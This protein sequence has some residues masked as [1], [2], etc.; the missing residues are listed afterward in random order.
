MKFSFRTMMFSIA[1]LCCASSI[2]INAQQPLTQPQLSQKASVSQTIGLTDITITYHRP[3]VKGRAIWG[4]LVPYNQIWRIGADENTTIEFSTP[5]KINGSDLPAGKY[6]LHSIPTDN[7]WTIIFSKDN[8][9]WGSYFYDSTRD[10]LRIQS[11]PEASPFT[12]ALTISFDNPESSSVIASINWDKLKVPFKIEVDLN[13]T[14]IENMTRELTGQAGFQAPAFLQAANYCIRNNYDLEQGLK[15]V[16]KS[17]SMNKNFGNV[18]AK[19]RLLAKTGKADE[20]KQFESDAMQMATENDLNSIGG[21]LTSEKEYDKAIEIFNT[22]LK[23]HPNSLRA[24]TGL[25]S[26]YAASGK[27]DLALT[28]Y[29]AAK[30]LAQDQ[31]TKDRIQK[32][33]DDL[34]MN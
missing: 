18:Y 16:D 13:K 24:Y 27:K 17:I 10:A 26:V 31:N 21:Q 4:Q 25:A 20:A 6:G 7:E 8:S 11:K 28:N 5:V 15:W 33:I 1:A 9:A 23:S 32:S 29:E 19:S 3:L 14:V 2:S 30:K 22:N 12:E 34:K